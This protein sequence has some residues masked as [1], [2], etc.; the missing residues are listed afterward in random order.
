MA[1][2]DVGAAVADMRKPRR[3]AVEGQ[4]RAGRPHAFA[5]RV[6]L[7]VFQD[8]AVSRKKRLRQHLRDSAVEIVIKPP[9]NIGGHG[10]CHLAGRV[11]THAIRNQGEAAAALCNFLIVRRDPRDGVFVQRTHLADVGAH[12]ADDLNAGR[13][14]KHIQTIHYEYRQPQRIGR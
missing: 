7:G 3:A 13:R 2:Q 5:F 10:A 8:G 6:L 1:A 4:H 14:L 12:G 9:D 11:S